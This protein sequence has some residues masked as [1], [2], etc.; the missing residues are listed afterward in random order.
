MAKARHRHRG[1]RGKKHPV[2]APVLPK[3]RHR[4]RCPPRHVRDHKKK[5]AALEEGRALP[6][7]GEDEAGIM[8]EDWPE[9]DGMPAED[10]D[11]E[12]D[13]SEGQ[14]EEEEGALGPARVI[15]WGGNVL[16]FAGSA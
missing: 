2:A 16:S 4:T 9:A 6:D 1:T 11:D 8:S 13:T 3:K 10:R 12:E 5:A 7:L 15:P 14:G